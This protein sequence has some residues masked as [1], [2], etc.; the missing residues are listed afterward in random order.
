M[1]EICLIITIITALAGVLIAWWQWRNGNQIARADFIHRF[2]QGFFNGEARDLIML[3][4]YDCLRFRIKAIDCGDYPYFEIIPSELNE[5]RDDKS[6][7]IY[8]AYEIDDLI[9]GR[10]ED[11]AYYEKKGMIDIQMVYEGFGWY[12]K[13]IWENTAILEYIA[14]QRNEAGP[15]V[16]DGFEYIYKKSKAYGDKKKKEDA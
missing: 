3:L 16:Y 7:R 11:I 10:F 2:T 5:V 12:I 1:T 8:T 4:D 13:T 9:L 6:R 14:W 15:D